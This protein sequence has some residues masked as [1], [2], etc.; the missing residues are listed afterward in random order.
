LYQGGALPARWALCLAGELPVDGEW[1]TV[2]ALQMQCLRLASILLFRNLL[3]S[4]TR[5]LLDEAH[6]GISNTFV[7]NVSQHA[8]PVEVSRFY[9][10]V[11]RST[12]LHRA[13]TAA[14]LLSMAAWFAPSARAL[15]PTRT[16]TQYQ[17]KHWGPEEGMPCNDVLSV[18]QTADGYLWL[19]TEEGLVRFD[20]VRTELVEQSSDQVASGDNISEVLEDARHPGSLL[21]IS[22]TGSLR[23]LVDQRLD[24]FSV[25]T[26]STHQPGRIL[27]QNPTDGACWAGTVHGLFRV[28]P[29]GEVTRPDSGLPDWPSEPINT[30]CRDGAGRLWIGTAQG[31]YRQ[32][33]AGDGRHFERVANWPGGGVDC[34]A[35]AKSGGLWISSREAGI[36]QLGADG[37]FHPRALLAGRV[38]T[39][40][41]EDRDRTLWAGTFGSGLYRIPAHSA[42]ENPGPADAFT[43]SAGLI[44]NQVNSL[45]EDREGGLWIATAKG[46]QVLRD[47]RFASYG[48]PEGLADDNA[49]TIF[50]D[51]QQRLWIG[52]DNGLS[53]L[54]FASHQVTNYA[55]PPSASRPDD[56][57]I[58]SLGP[59]GDGE[60]LLAGTHTGLLRWHDGKLEPLSLRADLD[61]SAV[62][63]MC[64]D[65][66]GNHWIGTSSGLFQVREGKVQARLT[67]ADG[68]ADNLV[69][70]LYLD[71]RGNLWVATDGGLSRR[72]ADGHITNFLTQGVGSLLCFAQEPTGAR[73]LF[74]GSDLGLHRLHATANGGVKITSVTTREGLFDNSIWSLL[75][76]THGGL[77]M[78]SN[79]GIAR[80]AWS[81][82]DRFERQEVASISP[83]NYGVQDGMRSR[84]ANGGHQPCAW[85]DHRGLLWFATVKGAV[86]VDP[87]SASSFN[88]L[89][90]PV[91]IE[92][93]KAD[94]RMVPLAAS[95]PP[96]LAAGTQKF[97]LRYTALSLKAPEYNRFRYRLEPFDAHWTDAGTERMVR[98]TNL[99]PG[100]YSF[101]VQA[102]NS[103]GVWNDT[104]AAFSFV[105]LPHLYQVLWFRLLVA[106]TV[107]GL[108]WVWLRQHKQNLVARVVNAEA[109]VRE[110]IRYQEVLSAAKEDAERANLAKSE[111][112]SR[113]SHELRTPLNAILGFAQLLELDDLTAQQGTATRHI[114][115]GG[116]H[117]LGL[118]NEVLDLARVEAGHMSLSP[119][120]VNAVK[121]FQE[122]LDLVRPLAAQRGLTL[123]SHFGPDDESWVIADCQRL[124][125]IL[126]NFL[127]NAL[128]FNRQGGHV[129]AV[130]K[131]ASDRLVRLSVR[132]TG[133]GIAPADQER[134]FVAFERLAADRAG[135][136]GTGLG[137][138]LAKRLAELMGGNVSVTSVVGEGSEFCLELPRAAAP[139][140]AL[141]PVP[142]PDPL[143]VD[144]EQ[145][146]TVL[147]IEDNLSNLD[148]VEQ[149]LQMRAGLRLIQ[150]IRG[151][152]G[153]RLARE[154]QPDLILLDLD[155]PDLDGREVLRRLRANEATRHI[156]VVVVSANALPRG[157]EQ[158]RAAGANAYVTKPIDVREFFRVLDEQFDLLKSPA[159]A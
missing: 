113:M 98:Y 8:P 106:G 24:A 152:L 122:A 50:E 130:C 38:V 52:T 29:Q 66:A 95:Q 104:G 21:F 39:S 64:I 86:C 159:L 30:I 138:A 13:A 84:E 82:L 36:G 68:L 32:R 85:R 22:S 114:L 74:V 25:T 142:E 55:T 58:L 73:D 31:L 146:R 41:L 20:G 89:P 150:A 92:E 43:T 35:P 148:L 57:L 133:L 134:I 19:G 27:V 108:A 4:R 69:R 56:G 65:P 71:G 120:P 123:E 37:V 7:A 118:I 115:R 2:L 107:L 48:K 28:G 81:D 15:D 132:D 61:A 153:L 70:A 145:A 72:S 62:R 121:V 88:R 147:Y 93:F 117:L 79:K 75:D 110:R 42:L 9:R 96:N 99:P 80:V 125:Q 78:S 6:M 46:L 102:A 16:F 47:T 155:L 149:I 63:A 83:I 33:L 151:D 3:R 34:I 11:R 77:W 45:F 76:D 128:K 54:D 137:L 51:R 12:V 94:G 109:D 90:P 129:T 156:P 105:L 49:V 158:L 101:K 126:V 144:R 10:L 136:E 124:K 119:E 14:F 67:T 141:S 59:A 53:W 116:R 112:L 135:V 1:R 103:D 111:F 131:A 40:L 154:E 140:L 23:R 87:A 143:A 26:A 18:I 139:T 17:S 127:S 60:T 97:E 5:A 44:D 100:Q 157:I 91:Q